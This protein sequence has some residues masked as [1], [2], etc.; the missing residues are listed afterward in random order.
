ME[1][2]GILGM[3]KVLGHKACSINAILA[4]RLEKK[5]SKNPSA[6]VEK[7]IKLVLERL[8]A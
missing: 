3:A 6:I 5:F 2:A 7:A 4:A 8:T 1:T